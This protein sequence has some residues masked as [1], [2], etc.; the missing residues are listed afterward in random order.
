MK[1]TRVKSPLSMKNEIFSIFVV[2]ICCLA[3][4][5]IFSLESIKTIGEIEGQQ[6][7]EFAKRNSRLQGS[8]N[9]EGIR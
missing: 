5:Y 3:I 4:N 8:L 6:I 9:N 1:S 2:A 7:K